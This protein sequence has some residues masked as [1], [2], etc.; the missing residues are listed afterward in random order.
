MKNSFCLILFLILWTYNISV[1]QCNWNPV[2][3][4]YCSDLWDG[5]GF[6]KKCFDP[7]TTSFENPANLNYCF[8]KPTEIFVPVYSTDDGTFLY[9]RKRYANFSICLPDNICQLSYNLQEITKVNGVETGTILVSKESVHTGINRLEPCA[10]CENNRFFHLPAHYD[11]TQT[12]GTYKI[13]LIYS[14]CD[15]NGNITGTNTTSFYYELEDATSGVDVD[16]AFTASQQIEILN[17]DNNIDGII[18]TDGSFPGPEL[19]PASAG[20]RIATV[21]NGIEQYTVELYE[22]DCNNPM[23]TELIHNQTIPYQGI[24]SITYSFLNVPDWINIFDPDACYKVVVKVKSICG[25]YEDE[26]YFG[27]TSSCVFCRVLSPVQETELGLQPL[28]TTVTN[29]GSGN[30][31]IRTK[32]ANLREVHI[33]D[34]N[35]R[36]FKSVYG[37]E[38]EIIELSNIPARFPLFIIIDEFG[39]VNKKM[40]L[41]N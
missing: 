33:L 41:R 40:I 35:G 5:T 24:Q 39:R 38:S 34:M 14:C 12:F 8:K 25:E 13:N 6:E 9:T 20:V 27:L 11:F 17:G 21:G 3:I 10:Y 30:M 7:Q 23:A 1:S 16:I 32:D 4:S 36:V 15:E 31:E 26:A 29:D 22:V 19:G 2:C 37:I 28:Q 18:L